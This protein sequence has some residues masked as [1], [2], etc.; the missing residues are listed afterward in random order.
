MTRTPIRRSNGEKR[1]M[2]G[3]GSGRWRSPYAR[4][5]RP[6]G[7]SPVVR[8]S[9]A[10]NAAAARWRGPISILP[11]WKPELARSFLRQGRDGRP[12][13]HCRV[14]QI[15]SRNPMDRN[16]RRAGR[17]VNCW[18]WSRAELF[19]PHPVDVA[20]VSLDV[21]R[22]C[23]SRGNLEADISRNRDILLFP[24]IGS[25]F[26]QFEAVVRCRN[27]PTGFGRRARLGP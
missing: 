25:C 19:P 24:G 27:S 6:Y 4:P 13:R 16:R 23:S 21:C 8:F 10:R 7:R 9:M 18:V 17:T 22:A 26:E 3:L 1:A 14:R 2:R 12:Q 5:I 15:L 20:D 11:K